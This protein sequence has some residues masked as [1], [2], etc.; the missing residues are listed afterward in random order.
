VESIHA[1]VAGKHR[2]AQRL[3]V[4]FAEDRDEQEPLGG[5]SRA[6]FGPGHEI[7]AQH[8]GSPTELEP[9]AVRRAAI[10]V[11]Q[12]IAVVVCAVTA[13]YPAVGNI[14]AARATTAARSA[15]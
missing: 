5:A 8:V 10:F 15:A 2:R 3:V 12:R 4:C 9:L 1:P 6:G 11:D 7:I 13:F 14:A